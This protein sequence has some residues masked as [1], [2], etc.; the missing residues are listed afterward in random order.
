MAVNKGSGGEQEMQVRWRHHQL[1]LL[2]HLRHMLVTELFVDV[3]LCCQGRRL[4][5]HRVL[6]SASSPYLQA[7]LLSQPSNEHVTIILHDVTYDDMRALL[8]FIYTGGVTLPESR[9]PAFLS[10]AEALNITVLTDKHL[11]QMIPADSWSLAYK[12]IPPLIKVDHDSRGSAGFQRWND[13][14]YDFRSHSH[15]SEDSKFSQETKFTPLATDFSPRTTDFSPR[16]T[17]FSPRPGVQDDTKPPFFEGKLMMPMESSRCSSFSDSSED[18]HRRSIDSG[19]EV[20]NSPS[21]ENG[22]RDVKTKQ[23]DLRF[24]CHPEKDDLLRLSRSPDYH[25]WVRPLPSL[26]PITASSATASLASQRRSPRHAILTPSPWSQSGR[27]PVGAPRRP[28]VED[29]VKPGNLEVVHGKTPSAGSPQQDDRIH[30]QYPPT[31]TRPAETPPKLDP[32]LHSDTEESTTFYSNDVTKL[33]KLKERRLQ[34]FY[35]DQRLNGQTEN[36]EPTSF[37]TGETTIPL[38]P[39]KPSLESSRNI[40]GNLCKNGGFQGDSGDVP[41]NN[42]GAKNLHHISRILKVDDDQGSK[43]PKS[44]TPPLNGLKTMTSI[45]GDVQQDTT[46]PFLDRPQPFLDHPKSFLDK[47]DHLKPFIDRPDHSQSFLDNSEH[48]PPFLDR[49]DQSTNDSNNNS[50]KTETQFPCQECNLVLTSVQEVSE[51]LKTVHPATALKIEGPPFTCKVC[52]KTFAQRGHF[53]SHQKLHQES[54]SSEH[55]CSHCGKVFLTRASLKVHLRTH[56]GEK[57]FHCNECGKQFS[58]LRNYKYHRSVHEGTKEF[59]ATCPECGKYFN[60]RGYLSSH[61]KIHRNRKEYGCEYC[62]KSFNQRVAYNMHVRI[63]TGVKP[64]V[65]PHCSKSFSR[66]M[67]LKQHLR[68][69]T[70]EKPFTC[71]VCQ[72]AFAD[73][74]NMTLHMRLHSGVK[75]YTCSVCSKSFTKKHHLKTHMNYHTG[76]KPYACSKCGLRFSQSSNMRTHFKKCTSTGAVQQD[77]TSASTSGAPVRECTANNASVLGVS[78]GPTTSLVKSEAVPAGVSVALDLNAK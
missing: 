61:M 68:I 1:G 65:C 2:S 17:D 6:L 9:L 25:Q 72:K 73:R 12:T 11:H 15:A 26:M 5:A 48:P 10:A 44:S 50:S 71:V 29:V 70:G 51:H 67:L 41:G 8:D 32:H 59:A 76:V 63:H 30:P 19:L 64:H 45:L 74:S 40:P 60:D 13:V 22:V 33:C 58:Q 7:L 47:S 43:S 69:H 42:N 62:G 39:L 21:Y 57:P 4:K 35:R 49:P 23:E 34:D 14:K 66:K 3:T 78:S 36:P 16:T 20:L 27:P 54:R 56:T 46:K 31:L 28:P 77:A 53:N 37:T 24:C 75:P 38:T 18:S 55:S 52:N